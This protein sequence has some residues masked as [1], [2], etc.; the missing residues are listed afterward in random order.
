MCQGGVCDGRGLS[1]QVTRDKAMMSDECKSARESDAI[2]I[3]AR[4]AYR[5]KR[6]RGESGE[7]PLSLGGLN[8]QS[9]SD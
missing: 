1:T 6:R 4:E 7:C 9:E 5:A 8:R 2:G 3:V